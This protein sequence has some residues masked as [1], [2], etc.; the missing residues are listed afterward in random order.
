[1]L[2]FGLAKS[3]GDQA[4]SQDSA[5]TQVGSIIGTPAYMSPEQMRGKSTDRRT[6][7]WSFGCVLYEMLTGKR[8]FEGKTVSDTVAHTLE[9]E[10]DWQ[11]LPQETPANILVLLR[12]CLEK[13]P[14]SRIKKKRHML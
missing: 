14:H 6:D 1:M 7:I 13:D 10:P 4:A 5:V 2:D 8:P 12:R 9:C 11:A 3:A